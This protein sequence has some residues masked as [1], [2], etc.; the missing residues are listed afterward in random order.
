MITYLTAYCL[1]QVRIPVIGMPN[2]MMG[3]IFMPE[4]AQFFDKDKILAD[5]KQLISDETKR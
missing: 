4:Y 1:L 5:L 2:V 3:R